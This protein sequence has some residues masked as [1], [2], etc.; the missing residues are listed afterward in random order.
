LIELKPRVRSAL[1]FDRKGIIP[2]LFGTFSA[3]P[4]RAGATPIWGVKLFALRSE[5]GGGGLFEERGE[6]RSQRKV[7]E[8]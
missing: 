4:T 3:S 7:S 1:V 8:A 5:E 2:L 6:G